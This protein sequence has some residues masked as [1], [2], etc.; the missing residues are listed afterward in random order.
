MAELNFDANQVDPQQSFEPMPAGWYNAMIVS[1]ENKATGPA[2]SPTGSMLKL[3]LKILD[4]QFAGRQVFDQLNLVNPNPVAVEI[5]YRRL[6]AY[7]H[8]CKQLQVKLSEQLHGIPIMVRLSIKIDPTGQYD[9]K[10]EIKAVKSLD[11]GGAQQVPQGF[12]QQA[13]APQATQPS[14][15]FGQQAPPAFAPPTFSA[16]QQSQ[17]QPAFTQQ[18]PAPQAQ[19]APATSSPPAFTQQAPTQPTPQAQQ[20]GNALPPWARPAQ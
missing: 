3:T 15:G 5:A 10:N 11:E 16:P 7:C 4:G 14:Q 17:G 12:G 9:P 19:V 20:G 2:V 8:A 18:A 13:P 1:S 6:S